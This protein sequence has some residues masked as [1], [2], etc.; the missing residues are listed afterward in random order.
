[1]ALRGVGLGDKD[2]DRAKILKAAP[3]Q[4]GGKNPAVLWAAFTLSGPGRPPAKKEAT[5]LKGSGR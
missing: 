3:I 5:S 1:M 2:F 4:A